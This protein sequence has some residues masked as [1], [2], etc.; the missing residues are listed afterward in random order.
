MR[1]K[2]KILCLVDSYPSESN[3]KLGSFYQDQIGLLKE[4]FNI[5]IIVIHG[6]EVKLIDWFNR[7]VEYLPSYFDKTNDIKIHQV[8]IS[9][10]F[11]DK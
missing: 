5:E 3:P 11:H 6:K 9:N 10:P 4:Y 1:K 7:K 2:K 8:E